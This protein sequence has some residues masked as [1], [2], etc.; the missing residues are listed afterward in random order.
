MHEFEF[1][2][3]PWNIVFGA[4]SR[5]RLPAE[6]EKLGLHRAL[7]LSTPNQA[8]DAQAIV[9]LLGER[10]AGLFSEA[11]MHVPVETVA[12]ARTAVTQT[13]ADCTVSFGGGSTTGLGK[14]L[15]LEL[16]NIALPTTYAGSE[17]TNIWG[18]TE[19]GRK[20]TG[21]AD[22]V[23]PTLTVYDPEL[24]LKLPASIAG[25]SGLNAMAQAVANLT[26]GAGNPVVRLFALEAVRTLAQALPRVVAQPEDLE[27]RSDALYGAC[28]AGASLGTGTTGLHHRLCHV[29]G[30]SFGTPHAETHTVL[31]PH[32]TAF[33]APAVAGSMSDLAAALGAEDAVRA[34]FELAEAVGAPTTLEAIGV[35]QGDLP[36]AAA[37]AT[38]T[39]IS[40]P[41]PVTTKDVE[42]LLNNAYLGRLP[43]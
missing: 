43:C 3:L 24:T 8:G 21:R 16:P 31:L 4:G 28:L 15:A 42:A 35:S 30:G 6:L 5:A 36:R 37:L 22:T 2:A 25:P 27:A 38:E 17:M 1:R 10:A 33:N 26:S 40:N 34:L 13:G 20:R 14:A 32:T 9:D 7:V 19:A 41:V 29:L 12:K 11:L 18:M 23:V 39:P